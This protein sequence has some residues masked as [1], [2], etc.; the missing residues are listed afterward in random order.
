ML[1]KWSGEEGAEGRIR[2]LQ[3]KGVCCDTCIL[4][5]VFFIWTNFSGLVEESQYPVSL[6]GSI[7][8]ELSG[9]K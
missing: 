2:Y 6:D 8:I 9:I 4:G 1:Q 5:L 7:T 3:V